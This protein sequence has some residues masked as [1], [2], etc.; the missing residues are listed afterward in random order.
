M[1]HVLFFFAGAAVGG[2]LGYYITKNHYEK[3]IDEEIESV[4]EAYS[5]EKVA[6]PLDDRDIS[7]KKYKNKLENLGYISREV[8]EDRDFDDKEVQEEEENPCPVEERSDEPYTISPDQFNNEMIG[9]FDK[10]TLVYW[11]GN[12]TLMTEDQEQIEDIDLT[13]GVNSLEKFGEYES[14]TVYVR[15]EKMGT[16]FEIILEEGNY[17]DE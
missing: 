4:K 14:D 6:R 17:A 12:D 2:A 15:N 8:I 7:T 1:K 3:L 11:A 10:E 9:V 5:S 16:D 13:V